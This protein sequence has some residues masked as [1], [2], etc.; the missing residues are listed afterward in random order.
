VISRIIECYNGACWS[1]LTRI[2]KL[3]HSRQRDVSQLEAAQL[4]NNEVSLP[5][6]DAHFSPETLN[7]S[8][9]HL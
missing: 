3:S 1:N 4:T 6:L 9:C 5:S 7:T 8:S 2:I